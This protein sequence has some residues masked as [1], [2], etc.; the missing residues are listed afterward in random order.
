VVG[1]PD[2]ITYANFGDDR[3]RGLWVA[4][5]HN[6]PFSIDFE[7]RP[8]NTLALPCECVITS[9]GLIGLRRPLCKMTAK[10]RHSPVVSVSTR[11]QL[12]APRQCCSR[13]GRRSFPI[14][15]PRTWNLT[16]HLRDPSLS[17]DCFRSAR[18]THLFQTHRNTQQSHAA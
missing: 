9:T 16:N 10:C 7:R 14:A 6:L 12:N 11:Q 18:K 4:G 1:I 2:V 8:C 15:R 3:L 13:F 5:G 17:S